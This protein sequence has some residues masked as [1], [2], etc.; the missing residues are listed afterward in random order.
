MEKININIYG[1][2]G[3]FGGK[4]TPLE[5]EITYC[6]NYKECSFYKNGKCFNVGRWKPNC[7][8]GKK[9]IEKGYTSRATKYEAFRKKYKND[10]K[11]NILEEPSNTVGKVGN[12][13]ILNLRFLKELV[14][15]SFVIETTFFGDNLVYI[16]E[17][18]FTNELIKL[19]CDGKPRA[20]FDNAIIKDYQEKILPR[21]I[22]ELKTEFFD[23]YNRFINE[24]PEYK[25]IEPNFIGRQAYIYSLKDGTKLKDKTLFVKDGEYLKSIESW[26]SAFLPF[27][28]DE[29]DM[30]IKINKK[31]T[32][33]IT[34]NE[35]VDENTIFKD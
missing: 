7:K 18:Q 30:V 23:I 31:M 17:E 29:A 32:V 13:F 25:K 27:N 4:E 21:F 8:I 5:A 35:M 16:A 24:Y 11:Y 22:Y 26:H 33:K 3:S 9:Q 15:G 12:I 6:D 1:G 2:K 34:N 10:E 19:I 20:L 14:D 28:A